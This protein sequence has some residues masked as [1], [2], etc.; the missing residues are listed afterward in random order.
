M[1]LY[2]RFCDSLILI[3][4]SEF[5]CHEKLLKTCEPFMKSNR[6]KQCK[7]VNISVHVRFVLTAVSIMTIHF[8]DM[9]MCR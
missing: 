2:V 1:R 6:P 4:I 3:S 5:R 9:T 7:H 8:L